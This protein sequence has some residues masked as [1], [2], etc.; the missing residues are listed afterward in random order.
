MSAWQ[1]VLWTSVTT[2]LASGGFWAYMQRRDST[3]TQTDRLLRGLAYDKIVSLGM[4]YIQRGW[5]TSDEYEEYRKYLYDPYRALGG[6]G[7]TERIMA[8]VSNLPLRSR[9]QYAQLLNQA[10]IRGKEN[11]DEPQLVEAYNN[12]E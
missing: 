10:K 7:V 11:D 4:V 2:V 8:E 12:I 6:N 5:I 1:Q 3:R 9:A